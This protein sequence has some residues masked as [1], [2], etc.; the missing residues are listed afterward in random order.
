MNIALITGVPRSGTSLVCA[1]LNT[2]PDCVALVEPMAVPTHGDVT[3]AVEE[4]VRYAQD[5]WTSIVESGVAESVTLHGAIPDNTFEAVKTDGGL[6]YSHARVT[7]VRIDK[8]LTKGF[9]LFI[10]HPALFTALAR[11]LL[12]RIPLYAVIRH[13][14][15]SLASW[16]TVNTSLRE[17][18][19]PVAEAFSPE[20][21]ETLDG[22]DTP[23]RRQVVLLR[24]ILQVYR[25]LPAA[26]VVTYESIVEDPG[27]SLASLSGS[28]GSPT[29][30]IHAVDVRSRYPHVDLSMLADALL[31]IAA[32][33]ECFY[34]DFRSSLQSYL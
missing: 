19:W 8:A 5:A 20:L 34:P 33:A 17:G 18:R 1:C 14:L 16:Q 31:K 22:E 2:A 26:N 30:P 32:D 29:H 21:R 27:K 12:S 28:S 4:V 11:P 10:K 23:L 9:R 13:P 24:W 15:A 25:G 7:P 3:R 6:R